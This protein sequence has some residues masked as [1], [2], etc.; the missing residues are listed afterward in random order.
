M[1][2][3]TTN[4]Y[5]TDNQGTHDTNSYAYGNVSRVDTT[6]NDVNNQHIITGTSYY[7]YDDIGSGIYVTSLPLIPLSKIVA[8]K[9]IT[10]RPQYMEI[11]PLPL[12][13]P[14]L[15]NV[16]S[17][18]TYLTNG[19]CTGAATTVSH[20]YDASG[21]P[22]QQ[23][24]PTEIKAAPVDRTNIQPVPP[25]TVSMPIC[26]TPPTRKTRSGPM[27]TIPVPQVD[28]GNGSP[29]RRT[30]TGRVLAISMILGTPYRRVS[31]GDSASSPSVTYAYNSTCSANV[32]AP[33]QE[34]IS[35]RA[36]IPP[37]AAV[38]RSPENTLMAWAVSWRPWLLAPL[39]FRGCQPSL[40]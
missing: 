37:Q 6:A 1:H 8:G 18:I 39:P 19:D 30:P 32:T 27:P 35:P 21:L 10:A 11:I 28:L 2:T 26:S 36:S 31:P 34:L 33:C 24:M 14:I 3:T 38:P 29:K 13:R 25:M 9:N 5:D 16:T 4:S 22:S 12:N 20:I 40:H 7:P 15:T 23:P 17:A